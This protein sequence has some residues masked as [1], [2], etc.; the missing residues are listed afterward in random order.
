MRERKKRGAESGTG[1]KV[2]LE[3]GKNG[4]GESETLRDGGGEGDKK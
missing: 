3:D 4:A 1:K 2:L